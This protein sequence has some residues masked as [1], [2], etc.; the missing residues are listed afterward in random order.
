[1]KELSKTSRESPHQPSNTATKYRKSPTIRSDQGKTRKHP[2]G[3]RTAA[4]HLFRLSAMTQKEIAEAL[5]VPPNTLQRWL[6]T[7]ELPPHRKGVQGSCPENLIKSQSER[8]KELEA[9]NES[10]RERLIATQNDPLALESLIVQYKQTLAT[11]AVN[12]EVG[13]A[14]AALRILMALRKE[15][16]EREAK[17]KPE[18]QNVRPQWFIDYMERERK[19]PTIRPPS[20]EFGQGIIPAPSAEDGDRGAFDEPDDPK[21]LDPGKNVTTGLK[22]Q[23]SEDG[24][25]DEADDP[26]YADDDDEDDL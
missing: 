24:D 5:S 1:M 10:Y 6:D 19:S 16:E 3:L 17:Q 23:L 4:E 15:E 14:A 20:T 9:L 11:G 8:I 25:D 2:Q 18:D 7:V 21:D 26:D 13:E 22:S 12:A